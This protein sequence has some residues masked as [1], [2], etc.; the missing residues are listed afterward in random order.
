VPPF[1]EGEAVPRADVVEAFGQ[2]CQPKLRLNAAREVEVSFTQVRCGP[3]AL[4]GGE[5]LLLVNLIGSWNRHQGI[6]HSAWQIKCKLA[7]ENVCAKLLPHLRPRSCPPNRPE[8]DLCF[9]KAAE[10]RQATSQLLNPSHSLFLA[11]HKRDDFCW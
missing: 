1:L 9:K 8:A 2:L 10:L 5:D 11:E 6:G 7:E 3:R 4:A